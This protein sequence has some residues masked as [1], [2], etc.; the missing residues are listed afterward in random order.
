M[1]VRPHQTSLLL[2]GVAPPTGAQDEGDAGA[3]LESVDAPA[4]SSS[5]AKEN[6]GTDPTQF[7]TS[8]DTTLEHFD[9]RNGVEAQT[10]V[11]ALALPVGEAKRTNIRLRV[12]LEANDVLGD[13]S[14]GLG[15]VSIKANHVLKIT[16]KYGLVVAGELAFDTAERPELG[17]GKTV[18]KGSFVYAKFLKNGAIF[19][20]AVVHST[21]IAGKDSR[22]DINSTTFDFYYVPRLKNP[23]QFVTFDPAVTYNWESKKLHGALAVTL[24][25]SVGK[26]FGGTGQLFV[27]PSILF[28]ANRPANWGTQIGFKVINF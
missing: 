23:K 6:N 10:W 15:D 7:I 13:G 18:F 25:Q 28:G 20:P 8:A 12:P 11:F 24:G 17:T 26:M 4:T 1:R 19:A 5:E 2:A 16:P 21:S 9:L 14:L 3:S 27:K 22:A